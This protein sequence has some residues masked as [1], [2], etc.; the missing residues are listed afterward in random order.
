MMKPIALL[1]LP[2]SGKTFWGKILAKHLNWSFYDLDTLICKQAG[3][4]ISEIFQEG[5]ES[6]FR[7]IE[8][9]TLYDLCNNSKQ[10]TYILSLG[11]GTPAFNNNMTTVN[12]NCTS[13]Y[14]ANSLENICQNLLNDRENHR[15]LVHKIANKDELILYLNKLHTERESAYLQAHYM[16]KSEEI[17]IPNFEKIINDIK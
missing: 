17:S 3:L 15:P 13:I 9:S 16:L 12:S 5:G 10:E 8:S 7:S 6:L 11:G 14:L 4:T 2:G 1:G